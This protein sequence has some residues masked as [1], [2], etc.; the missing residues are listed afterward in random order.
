MDP[1]NYFL[2]V[3]LQKLVCFTYVYVTLKSFHTIGDGRIFQN[4][5]TPHS[6]IVAYQ[7]S[8]SL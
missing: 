4:T 7:M 3:R 5:S 1:S 2:L 6:L 8:L